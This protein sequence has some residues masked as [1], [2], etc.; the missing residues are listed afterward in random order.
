M[1]HSFVNSDEDNSSLEMGDE[2][3]LAAVRAAADLAEKQ[4]GGGEDEVII[5]DPSPTNF[6]PDRMPKTIGSNVFTHASKRTYANRV[7]IH[8]LLGNC[9]NGDG[10]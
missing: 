10:H 4:A 8:R 1:H 3:E 6:N 5:I 7:K 9:D 2:G